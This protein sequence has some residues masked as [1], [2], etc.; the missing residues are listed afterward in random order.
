M[1]KGVKSAGFD[2]DEHNRDKCQAHGVSIAE[3]EDLFTRPV[4]VLPDAA[5]SQ[6]ETRLKAI[7]T[8]GEGRSIFLVFTVSRKGRE[9]LIRPISARYMHVK[10]I[11]HYE[12]ENPDL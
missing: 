12:E 4:M 9:R 2:W 10:E 7:G 3:I 1:L 8:T 5:H 6:T 11:R